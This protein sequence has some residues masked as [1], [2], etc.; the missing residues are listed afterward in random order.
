MKQKRNLV[1]G[2]LLLGGALIAGLYGIGSSVASGRY[3]GHDDEAEGGYGMLYYAKRQQ[4]MN[5]Q[6]QLYAEECGGCH[7]AYPVQFLPPQSWQ[8]ILDGLEDHFGENAEL[9]EESRQQ[10]AT[11]LRAASTPR[12][13]MDGRMRR[14]LDGDAPMRITSLPHFRH[15]HDEIPSRFIEGNAK[16]SSLSQCKACHRNAEKGWFDEDDVHI[17]GVG[18]WHD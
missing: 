12:Y 18:Y 2:T 5:A 15:E 3:G 8:K 10:L 6:N 14:N 16:V 7:M 1:I 9:D 11:F 4:W 17:P 13:S